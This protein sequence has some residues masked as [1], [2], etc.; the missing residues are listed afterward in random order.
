MYRELGIPVR[1]LAEPGY[2]YEKHRTP[3]IVEI[4][5]AKNRVLVRFESYSFSYG[6]FSGSCLYA[7][8]DGEW[9]CYVIKPSASDTI[10]T[11]VAWLDRRDWEDWS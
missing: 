4:G 5:E 8:R 9:G 7:Q 6:G 3:V 10:E 2:W 1:V 11:A